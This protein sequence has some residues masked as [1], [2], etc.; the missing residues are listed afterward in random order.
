[1]HRYVFNLL[2]LLAFTSWANP[3]QTQSNV[4]IQAPPAAG[5]FSA[6]RLVRLDSNMNDWVKKKWVNGCLL[7]TSDAAD[8]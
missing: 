1:M 7:Y 8:E 3:A 6:S 5:G 4:L 2:M